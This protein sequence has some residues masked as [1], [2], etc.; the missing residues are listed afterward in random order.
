MRRLILAGMVCVC[1]LVGQSQAV[2]IDPGVGQFTLLSE[3]RLFTGSGVQVH[4]LVGAMDDIR[5]GKNT[6]IDDDVYTNGRFKAAPLT[7]ITG[8]LVAGKDIKISNR[9]TI[10]M[11]DGSEKARIGKLSIIF[12]DI[13]IGLE[14]GLKLHPQALAKGIVLTGS[15]LFDTWDAPD[16][17]PLFLTSEIKV[18]SQGNAAVVKDGLDTLAPGTYGKIKIRRNAILTLT[19]GTYYFE[20]LKLSSKSKL[21][22]DTT[23]G[24]VT[25]HIAGKMRTSSKATI[26]KVG[27]KEAVFNV[28][29][30]TKIGAR[31]T[32]FANIITSD[33]LFIGHHTELTG[34][35]YSE[36]DMRLGR[37]VNVVIP[38][39]VSLLLLGLGGLGMIRKRSA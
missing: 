23:D 1:L 30:R 38:E 9:V 14:N 34:F 24:P 36:G 16:A 22:T 26:E 6:I 17:P 32:L 35:Y 7:Q 27:E 10:G 33:R 8:S 37:N 28:E 19:A 21:I 18:A 12:G 11:L 2:L 25:I 20:D 39:P 31:N 15:P 29:G 4:G 13:T 5:L 3:K